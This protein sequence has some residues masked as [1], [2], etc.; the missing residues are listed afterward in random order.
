MSLVIYMR[1]MVFIFNFQDFLSGFP[2]Y[3]TCFYSFVLIF[4]LIQSQ[5]LTCLEI[6]EFKKF[7]LEK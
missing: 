4:N 6:I 5:I 3:L 2:Q 1:D 7:S